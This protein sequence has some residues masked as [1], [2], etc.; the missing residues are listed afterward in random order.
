MNLLR[1]RSGSTEP[2][3]AEG[4]KDLFH[5]LRE[6][7]KPLRSQGDPPGRDAHT[8]SRFSCDLCHKSVPIEGLRQCV[9]CG[10]WCCPSCWNDGL[11]VC[12]SCNGII[13]LYSTRV[14]QD[15][16]KAEENCH[17]QKN[18]SS[19]EKNIESEEK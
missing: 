2:G 19:S 18:D 17:I 9:I 14:K 13:Q 12:R 1:R 4:E 7:V 3:K 8:F 16:E 15:G 5:V 10:R 6:V 11:Y